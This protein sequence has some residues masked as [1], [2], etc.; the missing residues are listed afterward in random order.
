MRRTE[1]FLRD[2]NIALA[3]RSCQARGDP[4]TVAG[5]RIDCEWFTLG[6]HASTFASSAAGET[7]PASTPLRSLRVTMTIAKQSP[8]SPRTSRRSLTI[9]CSRIVALATY[10]AFSV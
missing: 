4:E 9:L 7:S 2:V 1:E 5:D 3:K 10:T 8:R 6:V